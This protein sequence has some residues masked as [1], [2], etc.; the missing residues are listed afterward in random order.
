MASGE[1]LKRRPAS[2]A[3]GGALVLDSQRSRSRQ[4]RVCPNRRVGLRAKSGD[5]LAPISCKRRDCPVCG[6]RKSRELARVLVLDAREEPP[7]H[8][9]TLTT[10]TPWEE[11][12]PAAFRNGMA[13]VIARLRRR[14]GRVEYF[15]MVEFTT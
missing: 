10:Q 1:R 2:G 13:R 15:A 5:L 4:G 7:T 6:P 11:L 3:R 14:F 12:D 8:A 9:M